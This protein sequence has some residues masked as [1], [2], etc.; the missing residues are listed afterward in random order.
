MKQRYQLYLSPDRSRRL[1]N[2]CLRKG[3]ARSAILEAAL[4]AYLDKQGANE[5]DDRLGKRLQRMEKDQA[6]IAEAVG[7]FVQHYLTVTAQV[8][9]GD[10][11]AETVGRERFDGF[12]TRLLQHITGGGE[13]TYDALNLNTPQESA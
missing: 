13:F 6:V 11:V 9:I 8:P 4:D 1:E 10:D 3:A 5:L 7:L 2:L 12:K